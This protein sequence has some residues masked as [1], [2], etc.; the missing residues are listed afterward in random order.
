[1]TAEPQRDLTAESAAE[2]LRDQSEV[3]Y[4][5]PPVPGSARGVTS[6]RTRSHLLPARAVL[7]GSRSGAGRS[8]RQ[9]AQSP[10]QIADAAR[11]DH[12]GAASSTT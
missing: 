3:H 2:R 8:R 4:L 1:M 12:A 6:M 7:L 5:D 11:V 10:A 9:A